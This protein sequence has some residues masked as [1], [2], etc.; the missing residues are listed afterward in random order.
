M[1]QVNAGLKILMENAVDFDERQEIHGL[2][3]NDLNQ[4]NNTM[5]GHLYQSAIDKSHVKF[6]DIPE[7][8]G[9]ITRYSGYQSMMATI[10]VL[11][12]IGQKSGTK[13]NELDV[14]EQAISNITGAREVF[15]KGFALDKDFI[16]LEYN[17]LV[18]AVVEAVSIVISSY[19]DY[20]KRPD[21]TDIVIL[22]SNDRSGSLAI[23]NLEKFN[24]A[25]KHGDFTK[26]NQAI[27]STGKENFVGV[28]AV[29][30]PLI[31]TGAILA[32][33]PLIRE[34]IFSF[35]YSRMRTADYLQHQAMLLEIN[36]QSIESS[37]APAKKKA[38][39]IKK[40]NETITKLQRASDKIKIDRVTSEREATSALKSENRNWTIGDVKSQGASVDSTGF[41]LL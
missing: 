25:V 19:I 29:V 8:R 12:E 33:V 39:I 2:M 35:Y 40:Q 23:S 27:L 7:S 3:E 16:V 37:N 22:K 14:I 6:D 31:V 30:T 20:V 24:L 36:K 26:A 18:Y 4:V 38:E 9:N 41:Q 34:L 1:R 28:A 5:I 11:K 17:S 32:I 10:S 15:E 21:R 13:I